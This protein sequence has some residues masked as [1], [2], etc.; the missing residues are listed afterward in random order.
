MK[1][2]NTLIKKKP[3]GSST[4]RP[5]RPGALICLVW[6]E[7]HFQL[8]K[9]IFEILK[10]FVWQTSVSTRPDFDWRRRIPVP[11]D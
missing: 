8:F 2:N 10:P 1:K 3:A 5:L 7:K 6:F 9:K 4:D 11:Q